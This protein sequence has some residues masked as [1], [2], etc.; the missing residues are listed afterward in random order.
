[1]ERS[2]RRFFFLSH[3]PRAQ[4]CT[5]C[6][7]SISLWC[8]WRITGPRCVSILPPGKVACVGL[9]GNIELVLVRHAYNIIVAVFLFYLF[10][11]ATVAARGKFFST[12]LSRK[13]Q[14]V[15]TPSS[16]LSKRV[17]F[18]LYIYLF[19]DLSTIECCCT[20]IWVNA[21]VRA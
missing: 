14:H 19:I 12:C 7:Y 15:Q 11:D 21:R 2:L 3:C 10:F 18:F 5:G 9:S 6:K 20:W 1:M 17:Y 16:L 8:R 4:S 13:M